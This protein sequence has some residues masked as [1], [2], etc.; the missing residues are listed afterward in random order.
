MK[1]KLII[2]ALV[3]IIGAFGVIAYKL[4]DFDA[5]SIK[6]SLS[7]VQGIIASFKTPATTTTNTVAGIDVDA[8]TIGVLLLFAVTIF[9]LLKK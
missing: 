5:T 9:V 4:K 2:L 6:S 3:S 7:T 8:V 1:D